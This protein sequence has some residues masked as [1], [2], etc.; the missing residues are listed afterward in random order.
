MSDRTVRKLELALV[1]GVAFSG[2][3][4]GS[5][6]AAYSSH[7]RVS[8]VLRTLQLIHT[9]TTEL[10]ALCVLA[11]ILYRQGRGFRQ[12]GLSVSWRDLPAS[13]LIA[14]FACAA[15]YA[16]YVGTYYGYY[17][18]EGHPLSQHHVSTLLTSGRWTWGLVFI[19]LVNPFYEELIVRAYAMSELRFF[20][21]TAAVPILVSVALQTSYHLYQGLQNVPSLAVFFLI[22]SVYYYRYQRVFPIILAHLYVDVYALLRSAHH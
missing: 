21:G 4:I 15:Y 14:T 17:V 7:V 9:L 6:Y 13:L 2:A 22:L 8:S 1:L 5:I 12:I 19:A 18:V 10:A 3:W 11:Y 20:S 16:V